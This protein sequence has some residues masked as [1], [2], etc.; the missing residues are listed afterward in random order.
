HV[1]PGGDHRYGDEVP[2]DAVWHA[3]EQRVD[4]HRAA[5]ADDEAV[6]VGRLPGGEVHADRAGGAGLGLDDHLL[7]PEVAQ[8]GAEYARHQVRAAAG[9]IGD[10]QLDRLGG[11][12]LPKDATPREEEQQQ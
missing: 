1:R 7:A 5:V 10:D 12:G 9:R 3:G 2:L 6:A 8:L 11:I 4:R